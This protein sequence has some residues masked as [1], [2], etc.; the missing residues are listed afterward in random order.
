MNRRRNRG[1]TRTFFL[2]AVIALL[3]MLPGR[4]APLL[5]QSGKTT[6]SAQGPK[7]KIATV[8]PVTCSSLS[9]S[10]TVPGDAPFLA[11]SYADCF[12]WAEFIALNWSTDGSAF[13]TPGNLHPVQ[14]ETYTT[15]ESLYPSSGTLPSGANTR[16]AQASCVTGAN[17]AARRVGKLRILQAT[18][19]FA[20]Q[21][22]S[23]FS[24]PEAF[25]SG[26]AWLGAQNGTNVWY[27]V[28]L[29]PDEVSFVTANQFYN[30]NMQ[31]QWVNNGQGSPIVFPKG[32]SSGN[33]VG[34][35]E[36]KAAWMEATG[37]NPSNPGKW[38]NYLLAPAVVVG[39]S[40]NQC[41]S[42]T[43]ALVG[44]HIIHKTTSQATWVW[45][46]FEHVDNVPGPNNT[47]NCCDFY[48]PNCQPQQVTVSQSSCL[49]SGQTSPVTISCTANT[50]PPYNLGAGCPNPVPIQVTKSTSLDG[51]A[52]GANTFA[53]NAIA[54]NN[55][56]SVFRY[57]QLD[58][59][60]WSTNPT[61]DPTTPQK[62]PLNPT[63]LTSGNPLNVA[64]ATLET[65]HQGSQCTDCH[66]YANIA[67]QVP[68]PVPMWD[69]DFSFAFGTASAASSA[70]P[71]N[72]KKK[73]T[74]KAP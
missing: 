8:T 3:A 36:L 7:A 50:P 30:A 4:Q 25:P 63:H 67:P 20:G 47:T 43:V 49:A 72:P 46:T 32:S 40:N 58:D 37:Y 42:V 26:P 59:V 1:F 51:T 44:L 15:Q 54:A 53:V 65:Y 68:P 18:S 33:P 9:F 74:G 38:A 62:V 73:K 56:N 5:A 64:N 55:S 17:L 66:M 34:V 27:E 31:S 10:S 13:G 24:F 39:P 70:S 14:W 48:N 52:N 11:Q 22:G 57:Y 60:L 41:R 2:V 16:I 12:A 19:K 35:I 29:N 69:S 71:K 6:G 45:A 21:P 28:L 23:S 61:P